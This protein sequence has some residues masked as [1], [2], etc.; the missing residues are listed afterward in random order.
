MGQ[1]N[2][3]TEKAYKTAVEH[4]WYEVPVSFAEEIALCHSEL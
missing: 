1:I 4:G 3:L 2:D